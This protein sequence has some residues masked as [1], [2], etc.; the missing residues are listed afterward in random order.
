MRDGSW[1]EQ[2][3][4]SHGRLR[5]V[6]HRS[7]DVGLSASRGAGDG[8]AIAGSANGILGGEWTM[9][10][11]PDVGDKR[12][13]EIL[14]AATK[15][16]AD[17]GFAGTRMDDIVA[18]SGL[19]KG[20]LYWY[21]K[22]KDALIVALVK[23]L[24]APEMRYFRELPAKPGTAQARLLTVAADMAREILAFMRVLPITF[25]L[26]SLAFRNKNVNK[27]MKE[28]F[29]LY[30]DSIQKI[31]EQGIERGELRKVDPGETAIAIASLLE[32]TLLLWIF[33]PNEVDLASHLRSGVELIV[34]GLE[35]PRRA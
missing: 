18:E 22:N 26:Y 35:A 8:S 32:G 4:S 25:E 2:A 15:V 27:V 11:R 5:F 28:Y 23:R 19:S 21:F 16:F 13:E 31:V 33:D 29:I 3:T 6:P 34:R 7:V 20:L 24:F 1:D 9:S 30:R 12:R 10:A 17:R 14:N